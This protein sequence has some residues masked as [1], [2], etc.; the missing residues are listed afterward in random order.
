M[1]ETALIPSTGTEACQPIAIALTQ[2]T[3][4]INR[5]IN[6]DCLDVLPEL[7]SRSVDFVFTDP[8][9]LTRYCDRSGR[10]VA[11]DDQS[12]WVKRAFAQIYRVLKDRRFCVSFY[13]W[14]KVDQFFTAWRAAGFYPVAHLVW[15]KRYASRQRVP[16]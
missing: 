15:A 4:F 5:V 8:P 12:S 2:P 7:P 11:N 1:R 10:T 16:P 6:A 9:Y 14:S 13:G 3:T